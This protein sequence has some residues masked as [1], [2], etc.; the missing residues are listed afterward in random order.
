MVTKWKLQ[1]VTK[2]LVISQGLLVDDW[3][4]DRIH[5]RD[6][7]SDRT[8]LLQY[9]TSAVPDL[10]LKFICVSMVRK[11][12]FSQQRTASSW[13]KIRSKVQIN[14]MLCGCCSLKLFIRFMFQELCTF[15]SVVV[16][17]RQ[18]VWAFLL[19][20]LR[21]NTHFSGKCCDYKPVGTKNIFCSK[22]SLCI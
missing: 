3:M 15:D 9:F 1:M 18:T 16:Q 22:V 6:T 2:W 14:W 11:I 4:V 7:Y 13:I 8:L 10:F 12:Y 17:Q 5:V 19:Q 20:T 21:L